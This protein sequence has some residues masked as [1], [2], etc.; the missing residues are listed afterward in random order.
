MSARKSEKKIRKIVVSW[1][2]KTDMLAASKHDENG[3]AILTLLGKESFD[4]LHLLHFGFDEK[5]ILVFKDFVEKAKKIRVV[6]H[7]ANLLNPTDYKNIY[8]E[9]RKLLKF[10]KEKYFEQLRVSVLLT[11]GTPAMFAMWVVLSQQGYQIRLIQTRQKE[12]RSYLVEILSPDDL[13]D[14]IEYGLDLSQDFF[15]SQALKRTYSDASLIAS[16]SIDVLIRGETGV[17]KERLAKYIH[18]KS[19]RSGNM[20]C[21][22]CGAIP[23]DLFESIFFGHEKGS[24]TGAVSSSEGFFYKANRGT[25]FLDEIGELTLDMQVKLL[26]V[27]EEKK[28]TKIG[29]ERPVA[30]DVRIVAAT[31][32]DLIA[33]VNDGC[34]RKDLYFRIAGIT[35][36][37]P[38]LRAWDDESFD[39]IVLKELESACMKENVGHVL[40]LSRTA[41]EALRNYPWQCNIRELK[42]VIKR[43]AIMTRGK[44]IEFDDVSPCLLFPCVDKSLEINEFK[45]GFDVR[46]YLNQVKKDLIVKALKDTG[47]SVS[48]A[49]KLLG[50]PQ[51]TFSNWKKECLK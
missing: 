18:D 10:L 14:K 24:F 42:S 2:G 25:L 12:D 40:N 22:N 46:D 9:E 35:L 20:E 17:G 36:S 11:S 1:V 3:S 6:L 50:L 39:S 16:K 21:V 8:D 7:V 29:G 31:N 38:P 34:F 49:S 32:R 28:V 30:V 44:I 33:M 41:R 4:E 43:L 27:L 23:K 37:I 26:R 15:M 51:A 47:N 19:G 13:N 45:Q 48:R 5:D